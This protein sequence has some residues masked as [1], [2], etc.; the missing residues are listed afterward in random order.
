MSEWTTETVAARFEAAVRTASKLPRVTVQGY[1]NVWPAF[2]RDPWETIS[3]DEPRAM[4]FAPEP[5][6]IEQMME[7][8]RWLQWLEVEQRHLIWMR[9]RHEEWKFICRRIGCDRT[10]AWRR[11]QKALAVVVERLNDAALPN[12]AKLANVDS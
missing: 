7:T 11:W 6:A 8:M 1:F 3:N 4:H 12:F 9:A 2:A 5:Q 10:T